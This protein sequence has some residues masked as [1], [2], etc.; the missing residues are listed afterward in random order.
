[1]SED[2]LEHYPVERT[3]YTQS[4]GRLLPHRLGQIFQELGFNT[5]INSD[6]TNGIDLRV[7]DAN[8]NLILVAE[9][10]NWSCRSSLNEK[11]KNKMIENLS[12]FNCNKLLVY[13]SLK[14]KEMLNDFSKHEVT[15]LEIGYQVLPKSFHNFYHKKHQV[16]WRKKDSAETKALIKSKILE[17]LQSSIIDVFS[18][19][20]FC[21]LKV[22]PVT[23]KIGG[24]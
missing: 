19:S 22:T 14:N 7:Y 2:S 12:K 17:Y 21:N 13:T 15:C 10:L 3:V 18:I 20:E 11:R 4:V 5:W 23:K 6:Q 24:E 16:K 1:M 9:V 8:N